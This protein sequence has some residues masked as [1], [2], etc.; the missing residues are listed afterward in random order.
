MPPVL[1]RAPK[2]PRRTPL[3][4]SGLQRWTTGCPGQAV[5]ACRISWRKSPSSLARVRRCA[6]TGR[7]TA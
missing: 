5:S 1:V 3:A 4:L 7:P 2:H 6:S